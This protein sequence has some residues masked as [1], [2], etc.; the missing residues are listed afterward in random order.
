KQINLHSNKY[1][2]KQVYD[3]LTHTGGK[4]HWDKVVW[5]RA[6]LPKHQFLMWLSIRS[7]LLTRDRLSRLG[8]STETSCCLCQSGEETHL[9]LFSSVV[10]VESRNYKGSRLRR[11]LYGAVVSAL[12]Y[13]IWPARNDMLWNQNRISADS[14]VREVQ[15]V[16]KNRIQ[17]VGRMS[18]LDKEWIDAL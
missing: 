7:R 2:I 9:H 5:N 1:S 17:F 3:S 14:I 13:R 12:A 11:Q 10:L 4:V 8:M 16:V 18:S 6:A 15:Y